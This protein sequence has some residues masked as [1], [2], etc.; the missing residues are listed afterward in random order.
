[1]PDKHQAR[2]ECDTHLPAPSPGGRV[3]RGAFAA[4]VALAATLLALPTPAQAQTT[5]AVPDFGDRR[6]H[7]SGTVMVA[8]VT[9]GSDTLGHGFRASSSQGELA[10]TE[11]AIGQNTYTVDAALVY[12]FDPL[13]GDL[14]FSLTDTE[15]LLTTAERAALRL[16]VCD[17]AYDFSAATHNSL[18]SSYTW[19]GSLDW[20]SETT[21]TL[22]LS[23]PANNKAMGARR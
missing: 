16:H 9:S 4:L 11:F 2:T 3:R 5:C 13:T 8:P 18:A 10:P 17:T 19:A 21:R 23:L 6:E 15:D 12:S 1:M 20:S 22:Y 14:E 7:W